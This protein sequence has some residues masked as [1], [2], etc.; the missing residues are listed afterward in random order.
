[1]EKRGDMFLSTK[2]FGIIATI[3]AF[4]ILIIFLGILYV[5]S[6]SGQDD[7]ACELS[8]LTRATVPS[9]SQSVVP[10]KCP[11]KKICLTTEFR[12]ECKQL[13]G[14]KDV[15]RVRV[16][17]KPEEG[18]RTIEETIAKAQYDCFKNMK[19]GKLDISSGYDRHYLT[20]ITPDSIGEVI[21]VFTTE[22]IYPR[23]VMCARIAIAEDLKEKEEILEKVDVN[24]Y[25]ETTLVPNSDLTYLQIFTDRQVRSYPAT[26]KEEIS[27]TNAEGT[28]QIGIIFMQILTEEPPEEIA[29]Q[30]FWG[31]TIVAGGLMLTPVGGVVGAAGIVA[32]LAGSATV[33]GLGYSQAE[34]NQL[35]AASTCGEFVSTE[36]GR[37]GCSIVTFV[38]YN[39]IAKIN[40]LCTMETIV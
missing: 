18:A 13:A 40:R 2:L 9:S 7:L 36:K 3:V 27:S 6:T 28:D 33:A 29:K 24:K 23:C 26:F 35:I 11:T 10:L 20:S 14:E 15:E 32:G 17:T 8:V 22:D 30:S 12:G 5:N 21:D 19:W 31:S 38:D 39:D 16:S 25:I 1:M 34:K 4:V 37:Q